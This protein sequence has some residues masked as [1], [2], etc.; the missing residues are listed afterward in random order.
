KNKRQVEITGEVF[1]DVTKKTDQPFHVSFTAYNNGIAEKAEI[2]VLGTS[3]NI[4]AYQNEQNTSVAL[5]EGKIQ[6]SSVAGYS[7]VINKGQSATF[8]NQNI[9]VTP[10]LNAEEVVAWKNGWFEFK[11]ASIETIMKQV[12]RWYNIDVQY[13]GKINYHFNASI[14]RNVTAAQL[15]YLLE[16]TG[17]VHFTLQTNKIIVKP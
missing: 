16:Q 6:L 14:E 13:E 7:A 10:L 8:T 5:V 2:M 11:N 1:I 17:R 15:L 12:A 4:N 9:I 3:F